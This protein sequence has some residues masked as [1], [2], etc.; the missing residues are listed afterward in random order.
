MSRPPHTGT[1][2]SA[3]PRMLQASSAGNWASQA[4]ASLGSRPGRICTKPTF[5]LPWPCPACFANHIGTLHGVHRLLAED[6]GTC[7][8]FTPK[9]VPSAAAI[10]PLSPSVRIKV[11]LQRAVGTI[12]W[13]DVPHHDCGG[14]GSGH[15]RQPL[16]SSFRESIMGQSDPQQS[17]FIL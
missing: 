15:S 1:T 12:H 4:P 5:P 3:A 17:Q 8:Y 13:R 11:L 10:G 7:C 9:R 14:S 2:A 16:V 6:L